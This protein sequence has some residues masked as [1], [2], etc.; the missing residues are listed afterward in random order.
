[1]KSIIFS[2]ILCLVGLVNLAAQHITPQCGQRFYEQ[3]L[4]QKYPGFKAAIANQFQMT[5]DYSPKNLDIRDKTIRIPVVFHVIY[6]SEKQNVAD[7]LI[8]RQLDILND[9][10]NHRHTDTGIVR[11]I[12][13]PVVGNANIEFVLATK[14][15]D[16]NPSSGITRTYTD[17][18]YFGDE[19]LIIGILSLEKIERIKHT[20]QGG[21][22]GWPAD[23]YMNVWIADMGFNFFGLDI[24]ALLGL[25][26][27]PRYPMLPDNWPPGAVDGLKDGIII[28]PQT[29]SDNNPYVD[30]LMGI[31]SKGRTLVH[32]TGHYLGLRHINGD[33]SF[34]GGTDGI[35]DTPTMNFSQQGTECPA[36]DVNSCDTGTGDLPD[37][38]ENYMD[39]S[40]DKCQ[41]MFTIGQVGHMRKVVT[42]QRDTLVANRT[43]NIITKADLIIYPNPVLDH[44]SINLPEFTN[45]CIINANGLNTI[46]G[47]GRTIPESMIAN[48]KSGVYILQ[49]TNKDGSL[50]MGRFIKL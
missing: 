29:V 6:N 22:D 28:Q 34:C 17:T 8:L 47:S 40:N 31:S 4:E 37:M 41:A 46:K 36:D 24:V 33:N 12:F 23:R 26:T 21:F 32:E 48:L 1:M 5:T 3:S 27:P 50:S 25:A 38:W 44:L 43:K 7:S 2:L 49:I 11:N 45:Y 30:D 35:D 20:E 39:Y 13:K 14:D 16:G 15:P 19:G 18:L 10:F 42:L 9:A